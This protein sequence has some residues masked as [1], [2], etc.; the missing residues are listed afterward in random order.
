[1]RK[2]ILFDLDGTL[3]DS[4]PGITRCLAHGIRSVG[5][6]PPP[7]SS[8]RSYIGTPLS[9]VFQA[10]LP[11]GDSAR[12]DEAVAAYIERFDRLGIYENSVYPGIPEALDILKSDGC[13]LYVATAKEQDVALRVIEHFGLDKAIQAV[14]GAL[15]DRGIDSKEDVLGLGLRTLD[16]AP[17][18]AIMVGDRHHDIGAACALGVRSIG[19]S[20]GY[21]SSSE[22]SSA[23]A[24]VHSPANLVDALRRVA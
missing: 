2:H 14:F 5:G 22:L 1:M 23:H 12:I 10:L 18:D 16:I 11:G 24:I 6:N 7:L 9:Q 4:A 17:V 21:G 8:L 13:D 19:V 3:T 15:F 20:W